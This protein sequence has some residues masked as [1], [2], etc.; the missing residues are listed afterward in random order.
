VA[1]D[2]EVVSSG[3]GAACLDDPVAAAAWLAT[4]AASYGEPLRAGDLILSGALGPMVDV[5]P[6]TFTAELSGWAR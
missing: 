1:R 2:G 5:R 3:S 6:G 4:A